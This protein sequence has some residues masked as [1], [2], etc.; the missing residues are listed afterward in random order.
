MEGREPVYKMCRQIQG[1]LEPIAMGIPAY[2][3]KEHLVGILE[4]PS[5]WKKDDYYLELFGKI[6]DHFE[7]VEWNEGRRIGLFCQIRIHPRSLQYLEDAPSSNDRIIRGM[8]SDLRSNLPEP[9]VCME[10]EQGEW[11]VALGRARR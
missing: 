8:L 5:Q 10:Y 11:S 9:L 6:Y 3:S 7:T 1:L 2:K 4:I